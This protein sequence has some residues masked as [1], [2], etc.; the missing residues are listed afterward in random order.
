[1]SRMPSQVLGATG[2]NEEG[3]GGWGGMENGGKD[4]E[5]MGNIR[6]KPGREERDN[7]GCS[8][9]QDSQT[10]TSWA[11]LVPIPRGL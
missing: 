10:G 6:G 4:G 11:K 3:L 1:M 2:T 9:C 7:S 8:K 5:G